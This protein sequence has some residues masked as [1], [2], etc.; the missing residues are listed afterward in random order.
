MKK[1]SPAAYLTEVYPF[2]TRTCTFTIPV[3]V[4]CSEHLFNQLD[5]SPIARRDLS[6]DLLTFLF[7]CV[8]E[9]PARFLMEISISISGETLD[10]R[11][12]QAIR[13][14]IQHYFAYLSKRLKNEIR[15]KRIYA[16]KFVLFSL[17]LITAA[18]LVGKFSDA[19]LLLSILDEGLY[20]GGWVFL[21]E[22][23]SINFIQMDETIEEKKRA[24]RLRAAP[25]HFGKEA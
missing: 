18:V 15:R 4:E 22:A 8:Q 23:I 17:T 11:Q 14:A 7:D 21:W 25:I 20:I 10:S 24:E 2:D 19:V 12:E 3:E 5:H 16:L 1:Q 6:A 9:I 13:M